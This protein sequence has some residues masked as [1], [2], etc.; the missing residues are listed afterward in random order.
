MIYFYNMRKILVTGAL[1]LIFSGL[2]AAN[3]S[4]NHD[5]GPRFDEWFCDTTLRV[6]YEMSG[7]A[8]E[9]HIAVDELCRSPRWYG[10]RHRLAEL[11]VE[12]N[13]QITMRDHKSGRVI[14]RTSFSTLFQEWLA[15]PEAQTTQRSF[16]NVFI[17]PMPRD[18]ADVT[19]DLRNYRREV[20]ATMTHQ[21]VPADIL[22]RHTGERDVTPWEVVQ[23]PKDTTRC[24]H[25]AYM[26][27]GYQE[28]E[29]DKFVADVHTAMDALFAHEPFRSMRDR[30]YIVAVKS[31]SVE[32][33]AGEPGKGIWKNTALG[34]HWDTFYSERYLTTS[35]LRRMHDWLAGIPYEHIIALVNSKRYG[36]GGIYGEYLLSTID[37]ERSK[38]VVV[39][40]FGHSFCGLADE[41]A[42][43]SEQV[44]MYPTDVEPWEKNITTKVDFKGKWEDI[45]DAGFHEGAGYTMKGVWRAYPDCRMRTNEN[46]NFCKACQKAIR[47]FIEFFT[48][49]NK[50]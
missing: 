14:Y 15:Y 41:Y 48:T 46:P 11:P 20:M 13:G 16:E 32:S 40:E 5:S 27:E 39:H 42:Y 17:M 24:I 45:P 38:P 28:T 44:P 34:S 12:G 36:G 35:N 49:G 31:P 30:F 8:R 6:D 50:D 37:N 22:I 21:V 26:A 7:D 47:E 3:G 10:R 2:Y 25:L 23:L 43:E 18:T 29:M 1:S 9:Q 19:I 33:G 4:D